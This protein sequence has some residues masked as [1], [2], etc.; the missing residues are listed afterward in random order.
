MRGNLLQ[1]LPMGCIRVFITLACSSVVSRFRRCV[2]AVKVSVRWVEAELQDLVAREDQL[3]H[4]FHQLVEQA[5]VDPQR[6]VRDPA[7]A[8]LV[9]PPILAAAHFGERKVVGVSRR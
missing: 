4:Q 7:A 5:D 1:T 8:L 2:G 3:A 6:R 9:R